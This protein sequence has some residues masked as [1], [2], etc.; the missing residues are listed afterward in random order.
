MQFLTEYS[1]A[2]EGDD[3]EQGLLIE[4]Q[5]AWRHPLVLGDFING[6]H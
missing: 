2:V 1:E 3:G 4:L 6:A 5:D